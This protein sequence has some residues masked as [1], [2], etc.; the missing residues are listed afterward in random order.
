ML[1]SIVFLE[2]AANVYVMYRNPKTL[3]FGKLAFINKTHVL[4]KMRS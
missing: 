2:F 1:G 3:G 4:A